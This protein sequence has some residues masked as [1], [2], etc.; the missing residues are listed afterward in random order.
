MQHKKGGAKTNKRYTSKH[1]ST[2][3]ESSVAKKNERAN[4][5]KLISEKVALSLYA[6]GGRQKKKYGKK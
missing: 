1:D 6:L 5:Y 4:T 3:F 2:L